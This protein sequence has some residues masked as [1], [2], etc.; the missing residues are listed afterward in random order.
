[1]QS[2]S[3]LALECS[4][5][6]V[7]APAGLFDHAIDLLG[8]PLGNPWLARSEYSAVRLA[9]TGVPS[10]SIEWQHDDPVMG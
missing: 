10:H 4:Q 9:I 5:S 8:H 2:E 7:R 6:H 1:M 3:G